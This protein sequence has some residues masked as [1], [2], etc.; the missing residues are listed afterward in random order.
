[1]TELTD[2]EFEAILQLNS[3]Y[4]KAMFLKSVNENNGLYVLVD[5]DGPLIL[6][7]T[8]GTFRVRN[9]DSITAVYL[10]HD[11]ICHNSSIYDKKTGQPNRA[12]G[13]F[14]VWAKLGID[15]APV[16]ID[17]RA[18]LHKKTKNGNIVNYFTKDSVLKYNVV[19]EVMQAAAEAD[20]S[21]TDLFINYDPDWQLGE[22]KA[23]KGHSVASEK[24]VEIVVDT[25]GDLLLK[26]LEYKPFLIKP[27]RD[28][29]G[30]IFNVKIS[31]RA[32]S[33]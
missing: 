7:D 12:S 30:E 13:T 5:D 27:N 33:N 28:E 25:T 1:M 3:D 4:R 17:S 19:Q 29:L 24:D 2:K 22:A 32:G 15:I 11:I 8:E 9:A 20:T 16:Q 10:N 23:Y 18:L 21:L 14:D 26:T 31:S 6:E